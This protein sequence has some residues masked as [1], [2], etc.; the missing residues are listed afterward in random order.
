MAGPEIRVVL[1]GASPVRESA[2]V[3]GSRLQLEGEMLSSRAECRKPFNK[4]GEQT[5]G[6]QQSVNAIASTDYQPKGVREGRAAHVTAKAIDSISVPE[7]MLELPGVSG[8]GTF[9]QNSAEQVRSY[10]AA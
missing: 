5:S 1:A 3:P 6:P 10:L 4:E 8:G 7:R 2:G 9:G